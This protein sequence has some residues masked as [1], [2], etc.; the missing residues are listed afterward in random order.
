MGNNTGGCD[1]G[2]MM[3]RGWQVLHAPEFNSFYHI[4]NDWNIVKILDLILTH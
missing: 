4:K 3:G 2:H 1:M